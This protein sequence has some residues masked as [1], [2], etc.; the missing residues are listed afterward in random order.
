M[1]ITKENQGDYYG[2]IDGEN[3]V[4]INK[5]NYKE[6]FG[7]YLMDINN[8]KWEKIANEGRKYTLKNF[9]NDK[10]VES[11]IQLMESYL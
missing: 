3:S 10:A 8:P 9:N 2:F 1:E 4:F 5:K 6:K 11:L 7:E